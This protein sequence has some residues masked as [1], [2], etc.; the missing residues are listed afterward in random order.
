MFNHSYKVENL[1]IILL[2]ENFAHQRHLFLGQLYKGRD[3]PYKRRDFVL[4]SI[5]IRDAY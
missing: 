3:C 1:V 5:I 2:R 4:N